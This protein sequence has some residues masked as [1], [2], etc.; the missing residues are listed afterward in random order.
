LV[1]SREAGEVVRRIDV[2]G[3]QVPPGLL[4]ASEV[5][6]VM[7]SGVVEVE[8]PSMVIEVVVK[9]LGRPS[10]IRR[11]RERT[12]VGRFVRREIPGFAI[13][14]GIPEVLRPGMVVRR[15]VGRLVVIGGSVPT[16]A[17]PLLGAGGACDV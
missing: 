10:R 13:V 12:G 2:G 1:A 8:K 4:R 7:V 5:V 9:L 16:H 15:F 3:G 6:A 17:G 14:A 11:R